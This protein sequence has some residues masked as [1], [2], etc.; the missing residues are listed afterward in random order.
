M[1]FYFSKFR[2]RPDRGAE[3]QPARALKGGHGAQP[4][5]CEMGTRYAAG[6]RSKPFIYGS[7]DER[8][9]RLGSAFIVSDMTG[10]RSFFVSQII[11]HTTPTRSLDNHGVVPI[12]LFAWMGPCR[13]AAIIG[14]E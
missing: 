1:P 7:K 4:R 11:S 8:R 2:W 5:R 6:L 12:H 14:I 9:R 3:S 13:K 10:L